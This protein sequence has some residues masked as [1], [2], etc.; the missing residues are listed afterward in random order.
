MRTRLHRFTA[1]AL[2]LAFTLLF[3]APPQIFAQAAQPA[4]AAAGSAP[5]DRWPRKF[6]VNGNQVDVYTPQLDSWDGRTIEWHAAVSVTPPGAKEPTFGV[7]FSKAKTDV[8]KTTRLVELTDLE[9]TKVNFPSAAAANDTYL[10][11]MRKA[12]LA[13][14]SVT[15]ALDRL[16]ANLAILQEQK[17]GD[18]APLQNDPPAIVF[19]SV[20]AILVLVDGEPAWRAV[21]NTDLQRVINTSP[22]VLKDKTGALYLHLYD[23]WMRAASLG[24]PWTVATN[25]P[26]SLATALKQILDAKA[27]DPLTGGTPGRPR[28]Q[29]RQAADPEDRP[30]PRRPHGD[31]ADRAHRDGRRAQL[32]ADRRHAAALRQE[33][34]GPRVQ[35]HRRPEEL[36]AHLGPLV[37]RARA[38]RAR[39]RTSRSTPCRRTSRRSP[40]TARWRT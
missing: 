16:E 19:S 14:K 24:G 38:P 27:G 39:G 13:K 37:Q 4:A 5:Q 23:G 35:G 25:P 9:V 11:M 33:H 26:A 17:K 29:G 34:D 1:G 2:A 28:G 8:D 6:T 40:T 20:P 22:I 21:P 12:M 30:H 10:A 7:V 36:R 15:V 32:R 3:A 31:L 18:A